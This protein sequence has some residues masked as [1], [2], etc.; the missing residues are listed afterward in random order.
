MRTCGVPSTEPETLKRYSDFTIFYGFEWQC[1]FWVRQCLE[2][3]D[4]G[5]VEWKSFPNHSPVFRLY[6]PAYSTFS[7]S[8]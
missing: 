5:I 8:L 1:S 2:K 6:A 3:N 7:H 4:L